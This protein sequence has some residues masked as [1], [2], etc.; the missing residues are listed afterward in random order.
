MLG[1][2]GLLGLCLE[3]GMVARLEVTVQVQDSLPPIIPLSSLPD[4]WKFQS[5]VS[6]VAEGIWLKVVDC[7]PAVN[8]TRTVGEGAKT[9]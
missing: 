1:A 8:V 2:R 9:N 6:F 3:E 5:P 4:K 7:S